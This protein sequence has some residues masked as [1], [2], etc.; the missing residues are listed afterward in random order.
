MDYAP[1]VARKEISSSI[2][3]DNILNYRSNQSINVSVV[4]KNYHQAL[5]HLNADEWIKSINNEIGSIEENN[6]WIPV[7]IPPGSNVLASTWVFCEKEDQFSNVVHHKACLC[8][9]GYAQ[10][11]EIDY[12]NTFAPTRRLSSLHFLLSLCASRNYDIHQMDVKTAFL[13]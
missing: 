9:Q 2:S 11:E 8:V 13:Q 4:P 7:K 5:N 12:H 6:V 1:S 3:Q 10:K